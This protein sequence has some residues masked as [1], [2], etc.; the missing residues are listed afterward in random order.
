MIWNDIFG[1]GGT[2]NLNFQPSLNQDKWEPIAAA[3]KK[4]II[5]ASGALTLGFSNHKVEVDTSGGDINISALP[6]PKFQGQKLHVYVN[7]SNNAIIASGTGVLISITIGQNSG[8]AFFESVNFG[9]ALQWRVV[10]EQKEAVEFETSK[11][12]VCDY[13]N[14]TQATAT[15]SRMSLLDSNYVPKY[16]N[17]KSLTWNMPGDLE[18]GISEE[19]SHDYGCWLDSDENLKL[20]ADRPGTTD[21]VTAGFLDDS[22][23]D[24]FSKLVKAGDIVYNLD[25]KTKT[26]VKTT[27]TVDTNPLELNDDIF[28]ASPK[29]YKIVKMSPEGLGE[30]RE[31]LFT[32]PNNSSGNFD[33]SW[34]TQIQEEKSYN[35]DGTDFDVTSGVGITSLIRARTY[36]RQVNNWTGKGTW[37]SNYNVAYNVASGSRS[38]DTMTM[39]G[40]V[41]KNVASFFQSVSAVSDSASA[42]II[43]MIANPNT[44]DYG[45]SHTAA[46]TTLYSHSGDVEVEKPTFHH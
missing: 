14:S 42:N 27:A 13:I 21:G 36:I 43:K 3:I 38:G 16:L 26:T 34:Y 39:S 45:F 33:D 6:V 28:T 29:N 7:G 9:G 24:F 37:K 41:N 19:N 22:G 17:N 11:D 44:G 10:S 5:A 25:D 1:T 20:V 46:T 31:R 2:P 15:F 40:I 18:A 8:G 35:G 30:N 23:N 12:L 4:Q 32:V